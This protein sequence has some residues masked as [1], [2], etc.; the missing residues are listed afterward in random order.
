MGKIR[1]GISGWN[2][3]EWQ[4]GFY[5]DDLANDHRLDHAARVFDTIEI[6]GTFYGLTDPA[7]CRRWR[8]AAPH[9]FQYSVKG[10]RYITHNKRL[11]DARSA[12]ANFFASGV[13]ELDNRLGPI[14]WQLPRNH[15]FDAERLDSF[16]MMLPRDTE[17]AVAL[18]RDHDDR[19]RDVSFGPKKRH[20]LRHVL[21]IRHESFLQPETARI[22]QRHSVAL[23][24]SHSAEWPYIEEVTAGFVYLRLHG[25][26][27]LYASRY[28]D[29]DLDRWSERIRTWNS[30][31]VPDESERISELATPARK[32]RDVYVYF[33]N[34]AHGYAPEDARRLMNRV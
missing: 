7:T 34:T 9:D 16:L 5:P 21:E 3:D 29:S 15:K 27:E 6:N 32:E 19:L 28:S 22:A 31:D 10:S 14:L 25:P 33:D 18:A 23:C 8:D 20:R 26:D 24:L 30:G 2:Y 11:K 13:L 1:I 12:I 4:G 17:A